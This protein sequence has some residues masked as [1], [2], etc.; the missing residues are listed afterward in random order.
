MDRTARP[1]RRFGY[2]VAVAVNAILLWVTH[3]LLE[4]GWPRFLTDEFDQLLPIVTVSLVAT[5]V[6]NA[7]YVLADPPWFKALGDAATSSISLVVAVRT[8]QIFPFSFADYSYDWSWV[9]R[10]MIV[11]A[12]IGAGIAVVVDLVTMVRRSPGRVEHHGLGA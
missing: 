8:W 10:A 3:H 5:M 9:L 4:W 1:G 12:A 11:L 7:L 2:V 6:V